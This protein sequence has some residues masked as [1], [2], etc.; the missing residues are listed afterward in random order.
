MD[1]D[2]DYIVLCECGYVKLNSCIVC[3][4][5]FNIAME[6]DLTWDDD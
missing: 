6:C 1:G 5:C 3:D 2:D 4:I